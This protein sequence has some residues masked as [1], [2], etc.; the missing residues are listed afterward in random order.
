LIRDFSAFS[1]ISKLLL[2]KISS[3]MI[4]DVKKMKKL[5]PSLSF[6]IGIG[7]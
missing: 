3:L 7:D 2:D 4:M 5:I 6:R 1:E